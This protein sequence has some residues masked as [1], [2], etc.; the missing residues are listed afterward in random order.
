MEQK[1]QNRGSG[2][3]TA[4]LFFG[5]GAAAGIL[6]AFSG[7]GFLQDSAALIATVFLAALLTILLV[8]VIIFALRRLIWQRLFGYA[9]VQIEEIATPLAQV[10]E[11]AI[12][13]DPLGA[14]QAARDLVALVLARYAWISTRRWII[15]ALTGLIAAMAALAGTALL[16]KQ[17]QLIEVQSGLL[18]E[19]N[20]RIA[21]QTL[22]LQQD[23]QLAEAAR[24]AALA[25]EI[26]QIAAALGTAAEAANLGLPGNVINVLD[27][28]TDLPRGLVLRITSLSRALK[29]Y[30]Y[31]DTGLRRGDITDAMR[32][33]MQRRRADLPD[34]YAAMAAQYN[35]DEP[36]AETRLIDRPGSPERGQLLSTLI[37]GGV[38]ELESLTVAGLDL[39]YAA[40]I[41]AEIGPLTA[42]LARLN[43]AD[44]TGA[45]LTE[46]DLRGAWL[47]NARFQRAVLRRV[48]FGR[49]D[50]EAVRKPLRAEDAPFVSALT[51]VDFRSASLIDC[52]F[53]GAWMLAADFDGALLAG[54]TLTGAGLGAATFRGAVVLVANFAGAVLKG[55]DWE[56]AVVFGADAL[57]RLEAADVSGGFKAEDWRLE[58]MALADVMA[59]PLVNA[60]LDEAVVA[61]AGEAFRVRAQPA[62]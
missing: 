24:N 22:L 13:G 30:R 4:L 37:G 3:V 28:V 56:G 10:T 2:S 54:V 45:Y 36:L 41:E 23:V 9:E 62:P 58:P 6:L 7:L 15:A 34:S 48:Q 32:L 61:E 12:A 27:P 31:L 25:V 43:W 1:P 29:P 17:N 11:R 51:G 33:A 8:G 47:E 39:S 46:V 14:T 40:M 57:T 18:T 19:Q 55:S 38:R 20:A 50:P 60:T 35:W 53:E 52:N 21:E 16:F 5:F 26:T 49:L 44:F 42:Q 59:L